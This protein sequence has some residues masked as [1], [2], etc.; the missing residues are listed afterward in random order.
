MVLGLAACAAAPRPATPADVEAFKSLLALVQRETASGPRSAEFDVEFG[1]L[2]TSKLP[3]CFGHPLGQLGPIQ[4]DLVAAVGANGAIE[5]VAVLPLTEQTI[6]VRDALRS[7][8]LRFKPGAPH[9]G[10][11]WF[12]GLRVPDYGKP[13]APRALAV[14]DPTIRCAEIVPPKPTRGDAPKPPPELRA[15]GREAKATLRISVGADGAVTNVDLLSSS[16]EQ[17]AAAAREA[18]LRWA[19]EPARC[20]GKPVAVVFEISA[21][22]RFLH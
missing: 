7:S 1:R 6:C 22:L 21:D 19:Y 20:D 3:R 14:A 16:S 4:M 10:R 9:Y 18:A 17:W 2:A 5:D 11:A 13:V 8:R 12:G 15:A